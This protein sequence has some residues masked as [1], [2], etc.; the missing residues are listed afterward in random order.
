M[1]PT[2]AVAAALHLLL[3]TPSPRFEPG[4]GAGLWMFAG[5]RG[6]KQALPGQGGQGR[7]E[8]RLSTSRAVCMLSYGQK[9]ST[10]LVAVLEG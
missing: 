8:G 1:L 3:T 7:G 9:A 4:T 10:D 5:Q 6:T 2:V